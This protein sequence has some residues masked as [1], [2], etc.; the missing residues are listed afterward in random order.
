M[1]SSGARPWEVWVSQR[2][3]QLP[4]VSRMSE[5]ACSNGLWKTWYSEDTLFI[6]VYLLIALVFLIGGLLLLISP[7]KY[8]AL[9]DRSIGRELWSKRTPSWDPKGPG[10]RGLGIGLISFSLF[11]IFG[12]P[13]LVY[14]HHPEE[15]QKHVQRSSSGSS[16]GALI[17]LL[18]F[19]TLGMGFLVRPLA[20]VD[21]FSPRKLSAE[22]DAHQ[23]VYKLRIFGGFLLF[24]SILGMWVQLLRHFRH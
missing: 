5:N 10:S 1:E 2:A 9:L 18:F 6:V 21:R 16:W 20:V 8:Y 7:D 19:F 22:P 17:I 14:L 12:P 24:L 23:H 3:F 13:I 4:A 11:M 15:I